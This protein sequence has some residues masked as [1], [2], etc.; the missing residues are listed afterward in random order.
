MNDKYNTDGICPICYMDEKFTQD[1]DLNALLKFPYNFCIEIKDYS[2]LKNIYMVK[3]FIV[4]NSMEI[5]TI[6]LLN[7]MEKAKS[8]FKSEI[9]EFVKII[10]TKLDKLIDSIDIKNDVDIRSI[11]FTFL[12]STINEFIVYISLEKTNSLYVTLTELCYGIVPNDCSEISKAVA[13]NFC[14]N[15]LRECAEDIVKDATKGIDLIDNSVRRM[16]YE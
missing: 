13:Y 8:N 9:A 12:V 4:D 3:R 16:L 15:I 6:S 10:S 5:I 11:L 1:S 2:P 14:S 7:L